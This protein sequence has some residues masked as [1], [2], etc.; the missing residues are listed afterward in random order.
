MGYSS[1]GCIANAQPDVVSSLKRPIK[2]CA[3]GTLRPDLIESAS[4]TVSTNAECIK[5]HHNDTQL[6]RQLRDAGRILEPLQECVHA[7]Y[8]NRRSPPLEVVS[9]P[10]HRSRFTLDAEPRSQAGS[11]VI[12][13]RRYHK[14]EVRELGISLGLPAELVWRQP[15]PGPGLAIR[16]LCT[17]EPYLTKDFDSINTTLK[18]VLRAA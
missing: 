1:S 15:F 2:R 17:E 5:T 9:P 10:L 8:S 7:Q 13:A 11:L 14:D 6:V 12:D 3:Q 4:A 18:K 16:I